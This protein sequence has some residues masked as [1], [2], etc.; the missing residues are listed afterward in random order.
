MIYSTNYEE[1]CALFLT[2]LDTTDFY[3][4]AACVR[5]L[6][7]YVQVGRACDA[8][9]ALFVLAHIRDVCLVGFCNTVGWG[10]QT[11][12]VTDSDA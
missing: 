12:P 8:A 4:V 2:L 10:E 3:L 7:C 1:L 6:A 9:V 5:G 11:N